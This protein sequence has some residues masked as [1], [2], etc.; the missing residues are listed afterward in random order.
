MKG[1][2]FFVAVGLLV[3]LAW[4]SGRSGAPVAPAAA[5]AAPDEP[6]ETVLER[7]EGG[8]FYANVE[9][10]GQLVRFLVD[11]GATGVA[12]TESDAERIGL[13]FDRA[14]YEQVGMGASGPVRGKFV[15]LDKV[16]LDGKAAHDVDGAIL[17]GSDI[18]LL[19][20]DYL[21]RFSVEMRGDTMRIY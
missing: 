5:D 15:T 10:N 16:S 21:G 12:L 14:A 4:P 8:H 1:L 3:G 19:G 2:L 18:S 20:Q 17:E 13:D 11:T 6:R 9:V 7:S